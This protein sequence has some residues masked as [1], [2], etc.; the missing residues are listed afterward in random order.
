MSIDLSISEGDVVSV[1]FKDKKKFM[2]AF[3]EGLETI[4]CVITDGEFL[5]LETGEPLEI[6]GIVVRIDNLWLF[7]D[8]FSKIFRRG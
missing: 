6:S 5:I 4:K 7:R 2:G 1:S 3:V 8:I